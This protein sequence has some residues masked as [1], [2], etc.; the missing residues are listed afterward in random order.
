MQEN[1]KDLLEEMKN[2]SSLMLDLSYSSVFFTSKDIASEV[3][4]LYDRIEDIEEKLTIHLLSASREP[5]LAKKLVSVFEVVESAKRVASAARNMS[6]IVLDN[7]ELHPIIK[8]ALQESDERITRAIISG[9]SLLANQTIGDLRLR[10]ET[11]IHIIAIRRGPK[12]IFNPRKATNLMKNDI[13][14]GIG[15]K[16]SCRK[17]RRL[18]ERRR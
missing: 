8:E 14:I 5:H 10:T 16:A 17:L 11:G 13:L 12:W 4:E 7:K 18:A 1:V 3:V 2:L 15:P 9:S 6:Q